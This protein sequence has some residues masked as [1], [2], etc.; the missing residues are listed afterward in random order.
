[1]FHLP[2]LPPVFTNFHPKRAPPQH[3]PATRVAS[4]SPRRVS[5]YVTLRFAGLARVRSA[6]NSWR[7]EDKNMGRDFHQRACEKGISHERR[8]LARM[9]K[10]GRLG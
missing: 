6:G 9:R 5:P 4:D 10:S 3:M 8:A 7:A 1:M 2:A